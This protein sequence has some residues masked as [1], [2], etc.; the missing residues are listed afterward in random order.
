MIQL[1][2]E[3][4]D[5][6]NDPAQLDVNEGVIGQLHRLHPASVSELSEGDGPVIWVILIPTTV[7]LMKEFIDEKISETELLNNTPFNKKYDALYLCSA[8]TLPEFR[9][10]GL[11]KKIILDAIQRIRADHP[12]QTLFTWSFSKEGEMLAEN[13]ARQEGL[14]LLKRQSRNYHLP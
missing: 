1:A 2:G 13:I 14:S 8:M 4:F 5:A 11:T 6:H 3:V 7:Q 10:K 12:I 9:N